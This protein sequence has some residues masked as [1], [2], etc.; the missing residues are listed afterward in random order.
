VEKAFEAATS[1]TG[2]LMVI[3][4]H[5]AGLVGAIP[6]DSIIVRGKCSRWRLCHEGKGP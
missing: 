4:R 6:I 2:R 5:A 1:V 3:D